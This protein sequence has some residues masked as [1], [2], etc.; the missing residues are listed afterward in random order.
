MTGWMAGPPNIGWAAEPIMIAIS[1][2]SLQYISVNV[3]APNN[4]TAASVSMAFVG[5]YSDQQS[6]VA[7]VATSTTTYYTGSWNG[8]TP[9]STT[10]WV[11]RCLVGPSGGV[12]TLTSGIWVV[13]VKVTGDS[14]E[15][16]VIWSGYVEAA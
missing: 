1:S 12:T 5:P 4:P 7:A 13:F 6:A 9:N 2:Q 15:L 14:P 11:A 10:Q 16:P 3:T 8:Q